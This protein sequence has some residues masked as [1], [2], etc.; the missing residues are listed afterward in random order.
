MAEPTTKLARSLQELKKLQ[1]NDAIAIKTSDL[2]RTHRDRLVKHGF[3]QPIMKGWYIPSRPDE[4]LGESTAWYASYWGFCADYLKNRFD[5]S[6]S[7]SPEQSLLLHAGE[8][9]VPKQLVVRSPK[10]RNK[11][12]F[13]PHGT[14]LLDTKANMPDQVDILKMNDLNVFEKIEALITCSPNFFRFYPTES[15]VVLA[16]VQD[17]SEVLAKLLKGGHVKAAGRLAGGF[18]NIGKDRIADEILAT[19]KTADYDVREIDP[20]EHPSPFAFTSRE[21]SPHTNRL[22]LMWQQMREDVLQVFPKT[23]GEAINAEK[24]LAKVEASYVTDAYHSLSIEGYRVNEALIE[25]V[26]SGDWNPDQIEE[27]RQQR[28][29]MAARG[30]FQAFNAVKESLKRILAGETA[31]D[32]VDQDHSVWY[33]EL[34][35]PSVVAGILKPEDL[36]GYRSDQVFI[37]HSMHVPPQKEVVREMMP[38]LFDLLREEKEPSVRVVLGHFIFVYIHPYMDGNGRM[39]RF[40][41]NTMLASGG[42]SWTIIHQETRNDYMAALEEASV[43]KNIRPFAEFLARQMAA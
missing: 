14:S 23:T 13:F 11:I 5:E 43:K 12:T 2:S 18:R 3:L 38:L 34:F 42:Y 24:Y 20:F 21:I 29:A 32:V 7:L 33:R 28:D 9:T 19:M 31:G 15:R 16:T 25:K 17:A 22:K 27:D 4:T 1:D 40:L 26:S 36:A 35:A 41:M 39:G 37:R 10:A 8:Y 30:Y 6:W